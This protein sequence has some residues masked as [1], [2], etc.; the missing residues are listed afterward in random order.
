MSDIS[1][2]KV[3]GIAKAVSGGGGAPGGSDFEVVNMQSDLYST[4]F[5]LNKTAGEIIDI[6]KSGK[7]ILVTCTPEVPP[8]TPPEAY[9]YFSAIPTSV[10]YVPESGFQIVLILP[11]FSSGG[12]LVLTA[13]SLDQYPSYQNN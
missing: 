12:F 10:T 6:L 2:G 4:S 3:I 7:H 8:D 1:L 11:M 9:V 5:S 13:A